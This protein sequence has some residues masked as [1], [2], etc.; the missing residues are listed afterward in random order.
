MVV[1]DPCKAVPD[2][3]KRIEA[4][5]GWVCLRISQV[6][7]DKRARQYG[8][9]GPGV[10]QT[11]GSK[12]TRALRS[13]GRADFGGSRRTWGVLYEQSEATQLGSK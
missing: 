5:D 12:R 13:L 10:R 4:P 2:S 1:P 6:A 9:G 7:A 8:V 11:V 3:C